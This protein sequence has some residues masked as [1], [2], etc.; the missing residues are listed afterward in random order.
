MSK[1]DPAKLRPETVLEARAYCEVKTCTVDRG[2]PFKDAPAGLCATFKC[3][4]K[5]NLGGNGAG[6]YTC[7]VDQWMKDAEA[8]GL[9]PLYLDMYMVERGIDRSM[10]ARFNFNSRYIKVSEDDR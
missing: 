10:S 3:M 2:C 6:S 1:F 9:D 5:A 8:M 7:T 4:H